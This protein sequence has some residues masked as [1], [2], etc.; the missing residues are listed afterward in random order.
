MKRGLVV[1]I[2]YTCDRCGEAIDAIEVDEIDEVKF[3]FDCLTAAERQEIIRLDADA[4][5]MHVQSLCDGCIEFL[6]LSG[7]GA[8][9]VPKAVLH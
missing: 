3:G 4:G 6:G 5:I 1:K 9:P 8:A 2:Y 7:A